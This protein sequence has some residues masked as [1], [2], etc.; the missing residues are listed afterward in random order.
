MKEK[1]NLEH[2][3]IQ[4]DILR[5]ETIYRPYEALRIKEKDI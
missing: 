1:N 4:N 5:Y 2:V 3:K